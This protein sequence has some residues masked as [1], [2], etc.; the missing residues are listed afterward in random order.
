MALDGI[1][2]K[3]QSFD[4]GAK[5]DVA[6]GKNRHELVSPFAIDRLAKHL[7]DGAVKYE[8]RNWEKG[9]P[10][11]RTWA[12]A[13]RHIAAYEMGKTDEDHLVAAFCNLH[14]LLHYE[15]MIKA[16]KMSPDLDD[17]PKWLKEK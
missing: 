7:T 12:S 14:F 13:K 8:S 6:E 5:R 11:D 2:N 1:G 9:I 4:T 15:E 17:M 10:F 16:G 3:A